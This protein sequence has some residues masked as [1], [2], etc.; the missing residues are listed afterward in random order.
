M[1]DIQARDRKQEHE[2]ARLLKAAALVGNSPIDAL[3]KLT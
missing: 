2:E 3:A 1:D